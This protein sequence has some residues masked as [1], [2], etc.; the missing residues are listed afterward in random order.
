MLKARK[1]NSVGEKA[2][3]NSPISKITQ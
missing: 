2:A 1:I 3:E